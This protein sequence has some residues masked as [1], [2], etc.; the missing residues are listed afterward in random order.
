MRLTLAGFLGSLLIASSASAQ[1]EVQQQIII[2]GP[3]A[4]GIQIPFGPPGMPPRDTP[5]KT[6][7]ARIRGRVLAADSGQPL[8]KAQVRAF[9]PELRETR[10]TTTDAQG[11]F[12]LK[13]LPAGR[14]TL[15]ASKGSY[16]GLQYGQTRPLE[17]GK[18]LEILDAQTVERVDFALPRGSIITG[19]VVDDFGEA[20]ADVQ[21]MP[22]RYQFNQGRRRLMPTGRSSTTNDIGEFRIFGLPPG[23][24]YVSATLRNFMAG[25]SDDRSGYAPTY[26]P[27]TPNV[28]EAQ[29]VSVGLGQTMTDINLALVA[30]RT[31][32]VGG[33]AVDSQGR[34]M[35]NGGMVMVMQRGNMFFG[36]SGNAQIR[37]DG[38]FSVSGLA[39]GEYT[40]RANAPPTDGTMPEFATADVTVNGEDITGVRLAAAKQITATGRLVITD[41]AAAQTLRVGS[42]RLMVQPANPD[43][44]MMMMGPSG[45][46]VKDDYT[47]EIKTPPGRM[48][49]RVGVPTPGWVL[50]AVR[51]NG[52]DVTDTGIDFAAGSE[53]AGIEVELTNRPAEV[54]GA[55]TNAR[56]EPVKDYSVIFFSQDRDL[57]AG[58]SRYMATS[59]P[60]Q[61]GRFKVRSLPPGSYYAVALDYVEPGDSSDPDFLERVRSKAI[62][63]SLNEGDARTL[64]LK[65]NTSS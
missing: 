14:Y 64:D 6:G 34:P 54:S 10:M 59:R 21:V 20:V 12:E 61:D 56:G 8:R 43:D 53:I 42:L 25:E 40:L 27:G 51:W 49:V 35:T 32:K 18:P 57:W 46:T 28:A 29:R 36:P 9:S 4:D 33:T 7:T 16:V 62:T 39:P 3:G 19:R 37:P 11:V 5:L 44:M 26:Y 63:F 31:A 15:N 47:F 58:N 41:P 23:Q 38:S 17:P 60:D 52:V 45:G 22:M 1:A 48:N 24:Y 30:T 13:D 2:R 50:K 65:L 55:V